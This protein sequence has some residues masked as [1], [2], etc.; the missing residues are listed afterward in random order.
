[1]QHNL[2]MQQMQNTNKSIL[3]AARNGC[4]LLFLWLLGSACWAN[5]MQ[6]MTFS[7]NS[8][9][10]QWWITNDGVMGGLSRGEV[11]IEQGALHFKGELLLRNNGG[12]SSTYTRIQPLPEA[13]SAIR[14]KVKG[15][16][17]TYQLRVKAVQGDYLITYKQDFTTRQ[18]ECTDVLLPLSDFVATWRGRQIQDAPK[19]KAENIQQLGFLIA[20]KQEGDFYLQVSAINTR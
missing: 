12:F 3:A 6:I 1:M 10:E 7:D 20:N 15:D 11:S 14:L 8:Q 2:P 18:S 17:N 5:T 9:I 4:S 19:L 16:G 13:T